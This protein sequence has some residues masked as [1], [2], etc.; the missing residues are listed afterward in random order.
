MSSAVWISTVLTWVSYEIDTDHVELDDQEE[1]YVEFVAE[2]VD[3]LVDVGDGEMVQTVDSIPLGHL[4][5]LVLGGDV[6]FHRA[7]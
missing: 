2:L 5:L 6:V 7:L 1:E 3:F 4:V